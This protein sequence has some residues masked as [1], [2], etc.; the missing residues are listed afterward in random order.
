MNIESV[1]RTVPFTG[2]CHVENPYMTKMD[3]LTRYIG[4]VFDITEQKLKEIELNES[5]I[6]Y[7]YAMDAAQSGIWEWN[8]VTDE[9]SWSEQLWKLYGLKA[10]SMPLN[11]QLCVDTV[12]PDDREMA[13]W[14]IRNAVGKGASASL[15][16]RV[17]HPDGP[18]TGSH[19]GACPCAM[20]KAR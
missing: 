3:R 20:Q 4:T 14:I 1:T 18:F 16:Y 2:S 17:I 19:Q 15:E 5:K 9:L 7:A 11:N 13:S 8:V 10:N 6:R 12:H